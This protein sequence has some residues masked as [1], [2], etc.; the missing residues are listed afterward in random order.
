MIDDRLVR[1]FHYHISARIFLRN[2]AFYAIGMPI[3]STSGDDLNMHGSMVKRVVVQ[4]VLI[5][6]ISLIAGLG[7]H[8][9]RDDSLSLFQKWEPARNVAF[10]TPSFSVVMID[11]A[12]AL[13]EKKKAYFI[14]VRSADDYRAGHI[15]GAYHITASSLE[16]S[17]LI[18]EKK[19]APDE[20]YVVYC[21]GTDCSVGYDIAGRLAESGVEN[22]GIF[23]KG[24]QKWCDAGLPV[25][26]G[27]HDDG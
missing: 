7:L 20:R 26:R 25:A 22:V 17:T 13:F 27:T 4:S 5:G 1:I 12:R 15:P 9:L 6:L 11:E 2:G 19:F 21:G 23:L 10:S 3:K 18:G 24:W 16:E 8:A 14:D